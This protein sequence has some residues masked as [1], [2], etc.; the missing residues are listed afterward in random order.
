[1]KRK[2]ENDSSEEDNFYTEVEVEDEDDDFYPEIEEG[3][4]YYYCYDEND[5]NRIKRLKNRPD[6]EDDET[7][8]DTDDNILSDEPILTED[9]PIILT[10]DEPVILTELEPIILTE[11]EPVILTELEPVILTEAVPIIMTGSEPVILAEEDTTLPE[12]V[13]V[14]LAEAAPVVLAADEPIDINILG[15]AAN[16]SVE[17]GPSQSPLEISNKSNSKWRKS[18]RRDMENFIK[19]FESTKLEVNKLDN[20]VVKDKF[21]TLDKLY[22]VSFGYLISEN[23]RMNGELKKKEKIMEELNLRI[24]TISFCK[25]CELNEKSRLVLVPCFHGNLCSICIDKCLEKKE[26]YFCR[27]KV[28]DKK[29]IY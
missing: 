28:T 9:E 3:D 25:I 29:T 22:N 7:I 20:E 16:N 15:D 2:R 23:K 14:V 8:F 6:S 13:P 12:S 21:K 19:A 17:E 4:D 27:S 1:M 26:C 5:E 11:L 10:E 18:R 24:E